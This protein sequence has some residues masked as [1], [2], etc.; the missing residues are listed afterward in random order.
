MSVLARSDLGT[1]TTLSP[2]LA[3][4]VWAPAHGRCL[5]MTTVALGWAI[6][7]A[8]ISS[9]RV[10]WAREEAATGRAVATG[11]EQHPDFSVELRLSGGG[12][13]LGL[14]QTQDSDPYQEIDVGDVA[15]ATLGVGLQWGWFAGDQVQLGFTHSLTRYQWFGGGSVQNG[16]LYS[17][18]YWTEQSGYTLISPLGVYVEVFPPSD[19]GLFVGLSGSLGFAA[20]EGSGGTMIMAG[21]ALEVGQQLNASSKRG[22]GLFLRYAGWAGGENPLHTD[23]PA[24]LGSHELT[25]GARWVLG[26]D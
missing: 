10:A 4:G 15:A 6:A 25:L 3:R 8:A 12:A 22:L 2:A 1:S 11:A 16:L 26:D 13:A 7:F 9:G 18:G 5:R 21:Y 23:Y 19:L 14:T 17:E 20:S 24:G